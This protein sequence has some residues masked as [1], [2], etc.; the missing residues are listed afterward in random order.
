MLLLQE[1]ISMLNKRIL[2]EDGR[3][4]MVIQ[5]KHA[6]SIYTRNPIIV[7]PFMINPNY[8]HLHIRVREKHAC[9]WVTKTVKLMQS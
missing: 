1:Q 7:K 4:A 2:E 9:T 8:M 3:N 5:W 6:I